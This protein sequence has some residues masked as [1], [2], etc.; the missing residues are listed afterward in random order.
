MTPIA[1]LS[2]PSDLLQCVRHDFCKRQLPCLNNYNT[3]LPHITV[4]FSQHYNTYIF[5]HIYPP[6]TRKRIALLCFGLNVR[7]YRWHFRGVSAT[8]LPHKDGG[9][10]L[11]ALPEDTTSKLAGLFS[12]TSP[13]CRA[14]SREPVDTIF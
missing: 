14:P 11:S 10:T 1:A 5:C 6:F 13:K 2:T 7:T 9:V 3:F 4:R 12:I 8:C